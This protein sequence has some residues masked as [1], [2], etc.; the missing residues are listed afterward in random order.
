[1]GAKL[2]HGTVTLDSTNA[3]GSVDVVLNTPYR[4]SVWNGTLVVKMKF[5]SIGNKTSIQAVEALAHASDGRTVYFNRK[6]LALFEKM[7]AQELTGAIGRANTKKLM[8]VAVTALAMI[9]TSVTANCEM[10]FVLLSAVLMITHD[11][12]RRRAA[13]LDL[14]AHLL[15]ARSE[16][17]YLLFWCP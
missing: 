3:N 9:T 1:M 8:M 15:Q 14:R 11:H 4:D 2:M 7:Y 13:H 5:V 16:R 12:L 17:F 10:R 6:Q